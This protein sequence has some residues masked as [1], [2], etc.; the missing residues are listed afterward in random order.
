[1][2]FRTV[3]SIWFLR[4]PKE[5]AEVHLNAAAQSEEKH[6]LLEELLVVRSQSTIHLLCD[7]EPPL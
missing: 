7:L 4:K 1:L 6:E 2:D 5:G 3:A